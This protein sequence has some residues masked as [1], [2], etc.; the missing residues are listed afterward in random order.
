M[1]FRPDLQ[2]YGVVAG[3]HRT[4]GLRP[5]CGDRHR[6]GV[7]RV[8]L[9][10]VP[11]LQQPHPGGQL[12]RHIQHPLTGGD[13]LLGQQ[14]PQ[15]GRAL[16]RPGPLRPPLR[17]RQQLAGL[18]RAGAHLQLALPLFA[19]A[20]RHRGVRALVR[21]DPDHHFCHQRTPT[22]R[23]RPCDRGGHA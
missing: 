2:H 12:R 3:D 14:I 10:G 20:D 4:P 21:V 15:P 5:Q 8:V 13:Q 19:R 22:V 7:I 23:T 9:A 16:D 6:V 11:G 18:G 17:P 1:P